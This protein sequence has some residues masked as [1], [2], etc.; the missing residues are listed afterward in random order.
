MSLIASRL[1]P[2]I[3]AILGGCFS[4]ASVAQG[5]SA[6]QD[7]W[8]NWRGPLASGV[9][10]QADPP[11]EWSE[12][13]NVRW[14]IPPAGKGHSSPIVVGSQVIVVSAIP[15]GEGRQPVFDQAPGSHDNKGVTHLHQ[16]V[17]QSLGRK[18]G[19]EVW[20]KVLKEEFPHEGGHETGSLA[21]NSPTSDGERIFVFLGTRGLFCLDLAGTILWQRNLGRMD[22]LHAHGE[23]SSPVIH[24]D[25]L[26]VVW[27]HEGD[28]FLHA[29]DKHTGEPR[30]KT[31]R[32]E[33][34]SWST[35]LVV[36]SPS[37]TQVVVSA[38]K[39]IRGYDIRNGRQIWECAGLTDNVV[40]TPVHRNGLVIAGNSYYQQAMV[41]VRIQGS[42]G[43]VT[44]TDRVAW[45]L[46]RLTPYV[47]SPLMYDDTVYFIRHNQN[48]LSRLDPDTGIP[49]GEPLRLEGIRDFIFSSPVGAANR[50]YVT[51]RDGTTIVLKHDR[52]NTVVHVNHLDDV[53]S[54][55]AAVL[56]GEFYLRGERFLY[57]L[58]RP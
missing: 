25:L 30:W 48:V 41:A 11:S 8:M 4:C 22:T 7:T 24:G 50:I 18:D 32:D 39:R 23:G 49:R 42:S 52:A 53:F 6:P 55:T 43:D 10:P 40:S 57:C 28:S 16:F 37:G 51:A 19:R 35:P 29:F 27:D 47:S 1:V 13:R 38:T 56:G 54:A 2:T 14:K 26:I 5:A 20:R 36:E 46:N 45:K 34:T 44:G 58:A 17:V 3:A 15:V 12:T 33:K 31:P 21:S 9:A